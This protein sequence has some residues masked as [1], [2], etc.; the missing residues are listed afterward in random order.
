MPLYTIGGDLSYEHI[1]SSSQPAVR[2]LLE[3]SEPLYTNQS[4]LPVAT[5]GD[6]TLPDILFSLLTVR[7]LLHDSDRASSIWLAFA[8][9]KGAAQ[10]PKPARFRMALSALV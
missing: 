10:A 6:P 4:I 7:G 9:L 1:L 3:L 5:S 8:L 2:D